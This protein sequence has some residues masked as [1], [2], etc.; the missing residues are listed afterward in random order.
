MGATAASNPPPRAKLVGFKCKHALRSINRSMSVD[1]VMRPVPRT[2]HMSVRFELRRVIGANGKTVNVAGGDLGSWLGPTDPTLGQNPNDVWSVT[3]VVQNL[4]APA[5]YRFRVTFRWTGD[6]DRVLTTVK[7]LS[8]D[9]LEPDLRPD[10]LVKPPVAVT[11][12]SRTQDKYQPV[13]RNA[14]ATAAIG[15][16]DVSLTFPAQ[17]HIAARTVT[18]TRLGRHRS[19]SVSLFGPKCIAATAPTVTVDPKHVVNDRNR[20]NN[21]VQVKCPPLH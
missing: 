2:V 11:T 9:C 10:L 6:G 3:K 7:Q 14:G 16:F 18:I 13:I 21:A 12:A 19:L 15:P 5:R 17:T 4:R 20:R 1:A 8:R